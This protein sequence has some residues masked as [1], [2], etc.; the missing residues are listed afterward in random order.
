VVTS[1]Y[2]TFF[3]FLFLFFIF[4]NL[5][6]TL[7]IE[8]SKHNLLIASQI[9]ENVN[10]D[11]DDAEEEH[12]YPHSITNHLGEE[13]P[14]IH[15][16]N[17]GNR[18]GLL[19]LAINS[20]GVVTGWSGNS[21]KL[22]YDTVAPAPPANALLPSI[23]DIEEHRNVTAAQMTAISNATFETMLV[24]HAQVSAITFASVNHY[25]LCLYHQ[26]L[27]LHS[28]PL[29]YLTLPYL[30]LPYL[31]L[32]YLTLPYLTLPY[33]TL[34][35]LTLPY[36]PLP[37]LSLPGGCV[38][39]EMTRHPAVAVAVAAAVEVAVAVAVAL[40]VALEM[41]VVTPL[42]QL[43]IGRAPGSK[44]CTTRTRRWRLSVHAPMPLSTGAA[45]QR[46]EMRN[47]TRLSRYDALQIKLLTRCFFN[48]AHIY[49]HLHCTHT[50]F[51]TVRFAAKYCCAVICY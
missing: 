46:H 14:L 17:T 43:S 41:A 31:T 38:R 50:A 12:P 49:V 21:H 51:G 19:T 23:V 8:Y 16:G 47:K 40:A 11:D 28:L 36:L 48:G 29:P 25:L 45:P 10:A 37:Y 34:P 13:L 5:C 18:V 42:L 27:T 26:T 30:T 22:K 3:S 15:A 6:T 2:V 32:P 7:T 39:C 35:S 20:A 1:A 4:F 9:M 24:M 44:S 33:L